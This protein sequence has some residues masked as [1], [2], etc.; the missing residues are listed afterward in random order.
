[1]KPSDIAEQLSISQRRAESL[2]AEGAFGPRIKIGHRTVRVQQA[3]VDAYL[4]RLE[5]GERGAAS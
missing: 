4:R 1:V 3:G 5:R 2:C